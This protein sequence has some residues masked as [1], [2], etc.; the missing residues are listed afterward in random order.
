MIGF[1]IKSSLMIMVYFIGMVTFGFNDDEKK[2]IY[3]M[4]HIK[5]G[6][7]KWVYLKEK[8]Y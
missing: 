6:K 4:L 5:G 2:L 8:H 1:A 7:N 3:S